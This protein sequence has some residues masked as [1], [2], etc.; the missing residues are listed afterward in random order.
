VASVNNSGLVTAVSAGTATITVTTQDGGYTANSTIT[1]S[2]GQSGGHIIYEAENAT[3][4]G[5]NVSTG[6]AGYSGTG[7]VTL[8][9]GSVKITWT[10]NVASQ[11]QYEIIMGY[12][13][14]HGDK[15]N[16]LYI[17]GTMMQNTLYPAS[18]SWTERIL[19]NFSLNAGNNTIELRPSWGWMHV[20]YLKVS[21][22]TKSA[23]V[24]TGIEQTREVKAMDVYPN[25][26]TGETLYLKILD[27]ELDEV[28]IEIF[29]ITG[30][31]V[32]QSIEKTSDVIV[33]H[34]ALKTGVYILKVDSHT[35][36]LIVK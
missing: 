21:T 14:Q 20:D 4:T 30:S 10:V 7:Y 32:F 25:P 27:K 19:G 15:R 3:L 1:V 33:L 8:T 31:K 35:Q 22:G 17:N 24:V 23:A 16:D 34:P 11:G 29:N 18:S 36:K 28:S 9:S 2:T 5:L 26:S 12:Y 13:G 6:L